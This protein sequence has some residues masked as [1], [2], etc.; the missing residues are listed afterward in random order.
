MDK[1]FEQFRIACNQYY[2]FN[3]EKFNEFK[4]ICFIK[5]VKKR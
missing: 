4:N 1:Y 3:D 2:N 5:E